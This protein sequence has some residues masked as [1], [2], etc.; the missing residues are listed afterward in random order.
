LNHFAKIFVH[1]LMLL[2]AIH[3]SC[4]LCWFEC[5]KTSIWLCQVWVWK[6]KM[7]N[8]FVVLF[9]SFFNIIVLSKITSIEVTQNVSIKQTKQEVKLVFH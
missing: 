7:P 1:A 6:E 3:V 2:C 4:K 5:E 9:V 8:Q